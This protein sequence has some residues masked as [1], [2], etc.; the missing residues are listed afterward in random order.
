MQPERSLKAPF[1]VG[2][3]C[4]ST[5]SLLAHCGQDYESGPLT[6][7]DLSA[8]LSMSSYEKAQEPYVYGKY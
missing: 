5:E 6:F 3:D 8:T 4:D 2:E 7:P 1:I